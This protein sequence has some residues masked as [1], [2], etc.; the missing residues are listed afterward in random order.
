LRKKKEE[1]EINTFTNNPAK[2]VVS[3]DFD[4]CGGEFL[5]EFIVSSGKVSLL[6]LDN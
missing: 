4:L 3:Y 5:A 2:C 6:I 1:G